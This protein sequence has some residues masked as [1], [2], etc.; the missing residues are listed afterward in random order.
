MPEGA[1][2]PGLAGRG[3]LVYRRGLD[4]SRSECVSLPGPLGRGGYDV[5]P[6]ALGV[7]PLHHQS[8]WVHPELGDDVAEFLQA[9]IGKARHQVLFAVVS[10][11]LEWIELGWRPAAGAFHP[12]GHLDE[13]GELWVCIQPP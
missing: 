10:K 3:S 4:R 12:G 7:C 5:L 9:E 11:D 1:R 13:A 2:N 8:T 6:D